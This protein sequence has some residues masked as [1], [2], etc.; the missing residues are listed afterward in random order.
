MMEEE[1]ATFIPLE[2]PKS[3]L[4][5]GHAQLYRIVSTNGE[6]KTVE[7]SSA[8]EAIA[9]SGI[10]RPLKIISGVAE[11]N[12]MLQKSVLVAENGHVSTD[13]NIENNVADMSFL[14]FKE[15]EDT[16]KEPFEEV[17]LY[18]LAKKRPAPDF[19]VETTNGTNGAH[20]VNGTNGHHHAPE[21]EPVPAPPPAALPPTESGIIEALMDEPYM[22]PEPLVLSPELQ[23]LTEKE[24][25]EDEISKLLGE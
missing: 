16:V 24:L 6:V 11:K 9:K 20:A 19:A 1:N 25:S 13:I 18:N 3:H 14:I 22:P 8:H 2:I 4:M 17:S 23:A 7:A 15:L 5:D 12:R 21:P 10:A